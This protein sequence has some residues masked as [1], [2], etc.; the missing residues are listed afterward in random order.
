MNSNLKRIK[1]IAG[2][3]LGIAGLNFIVFVI[4]AICIGGDALNGRTEGGHYF[5]ANHGKLTEVSR[6]VWI[7]SR[8]HACSVMVT[9]PLGI[10][11]GGGMLVYAQMK[12]REAAGQH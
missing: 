10:F 3:L 7:Y 1:I 11:F 9:H 8:I 2:I 4:A 6:A 12:E 5:V